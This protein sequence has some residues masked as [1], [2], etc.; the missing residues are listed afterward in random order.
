MVILNEFFQGHP[1][2]RVPLSVKNIGAAGT[3]CLVESMELINNNSFINNFTSNEP[4]SYQKYFPMQMPVGDNVSNILAS[5]PNYSSFDSVGNVG[6]LTTFS[7][8]Y[9]YPQE[10][11]KTNC[12][13]SYRIKAR[14][15]LR[16]DN[17]DSMPFSVWFNPVFLGSPQGYFEATLIIKWAEVTNFTTGGL[18]NENVMDDSL[19]N[20]GCVWR[21]YR[22]HFCGKLNKSGFIEMDRTQWD[23]IAEIDTIGILNVINIKA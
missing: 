12:T 4:N 20:T 9:P 11:I 22:V 6:A 14:Y 2:R 16:R 1:I 23:D 5:Y 7:C 10:W 3:V 19:Y 18:L 17:N 21:E 13:A 8:N 15:T